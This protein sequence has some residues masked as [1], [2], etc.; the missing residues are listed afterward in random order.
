MLK[1]EILE[2]YGELFRR[3]GV[4]VRTTTKEDLERIVRFRCKHRHSAFSHPRCAREALGITETVGALD[5][6]TSNIHA[7]FGIILSWAIKTVGEKEIFFDVLKE[8]DLREGT[9]DKRIV[10]T[11]IEQMKK[12]SRLCG[13]YSTYFDLPWLRTRAEYWGLEFPGY[14][15]I[16]HTDV[17][18]IAKKKLKLH[19]NR[20]GSISETILHK[21]I[22]SRIHPKLWVEVQFGTVKQRKAALDYILEHNRK[23]VLQLEQNYLRLRKYVKEGK[24]SI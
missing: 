3:L 24:T 14:G 23:D 9:Y 8:A 4:N 19:S 1:R 11:C 6:E 2:K 17:W 15:E 13:Q 5:I 16:Y 12:Y 22:K 18:R 10:A 20:Q 21:N 7:D